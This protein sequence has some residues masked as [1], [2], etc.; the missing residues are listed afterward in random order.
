MRVL[1]SVLALAAVLT[2]PACGP[3]MAPECPPLRAVASA[4]LAP[5]PDGLELTEMGTVTG[6]QVDAEQV[7]ATIQ[8]DSTVGDATTVV[9]KHF[10]RIGWTVVN[11]DNEG[12]EAEIFVVRDADTGLINIREAECAGRVVMDVTL[13]P[14]AARTPAPS[15][16]A[17][18]GA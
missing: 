9:Q 18:P 10:E 12:F 13:V 3:E 7:T 14:A 11:T 4:S 17:S 1:W 5:L 8:R 2:V 15:G 16:S 6:V